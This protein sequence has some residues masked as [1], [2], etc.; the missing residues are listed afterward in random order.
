MVNSTKTEEPLGKFTGLGVILWY[1][2]NQVSEE[3]MCSLTPESKNH[4]SDLVWR[5]HEKMEDMLDGLE[6]KE[7]EE[8]WIWLTPE[9]EDVAGSK[10]TCCNKLI[11]WTYLAWEILQLGSEIAS[12]ILPD[13]ASTLSI[14]LE[15]LI[16]E[17]C[18][19]KLG[20]PCFW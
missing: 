19:W 8:V 4:N 17:A 12:L 13:C 15:T 14:L 9:G 5:E 1:E 7:L 10:F 3:T 18:F 20:C 16:E 6:E 11:S 2:V